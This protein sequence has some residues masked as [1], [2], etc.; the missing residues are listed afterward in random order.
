MYFAGFVGQGVCPAGG[1]HEHTN[2]FAYSMIFDAPPDPNTQPGWQSCQKCQGM[3]FSGFPAKGVCPAGGQHDGTSSFNYA[4]QHDLPPT[5]NIQQD[6]R[7]CA[8]CLGL[9]FGPF[10]GKCPAGGE[11]DA[12]GSFNYGLP[13]QSFDPD[14]QVFDSDPLTSNLPL[15]GSVHIVMRK[16]GNFAFTSH[17]HDSGF[18]NIDYV[19]SAVVMM[20]TG[21][22]FTFQHSGHTEGTSA[23]LP[24]G[25]PNRNDDFVVEGSDPGITAE[26]DGMPGAKMVAGID[27]KDTL[28]GG[29]Q[30]IL[31]DLLNEA[32]QELGKAA[33]AA[34]IAL[35]F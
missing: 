32:A 5:P 9:F 29:L 33:E 20:P 12:A 4:I 7:A 27:G 22:A 35:V 21:T 15:G 6:F 10:K 34:V 2:S 13:V 30:G 26:F 16:D 8:K 1:Q 11:H 28:V 25:T 31:N 19:V 17:A 24:F 18:D 3:Y 14:T 23:G